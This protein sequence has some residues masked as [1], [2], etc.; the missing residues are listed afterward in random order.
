M[1]VGGKEIDACA[2]IS[3]T[4]GGQRFQ[5]DQVTVGAGINPTVVKLHAA[6]EMSRSSFRRFFFWNRN[7]L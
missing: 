6:V 1:H 5:I 7:I 4:P 2:E 3:S